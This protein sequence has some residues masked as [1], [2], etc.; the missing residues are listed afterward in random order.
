MNLEK[1]NR[2]QGP[3]KPNL[4]ET[5]RFLEGFCDFEKKTLKYSAKMEIELRIYKKMYI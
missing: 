3:K 4:N 5:Q 1:V 2:T